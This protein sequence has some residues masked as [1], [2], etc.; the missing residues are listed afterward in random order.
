MIAA[1]YEIVID[2]SRFDSFLD[3][4]GEHVQASIEARTS[5]ETEGPL[6]HLETAQDVTRPGRDMELQA[7]F[8]RAHQILEQMG[9]R[10]A[11]PSL[12][13]QISGAR[14]PLLA[15]GETGAVLARSPACEG[16]LGGLDCAQ[17][18]KAELTAQSG[19]LLDDLLL[20]ARDHGPD[21]AASVVLTTGRTPRHLIARLVDT[22]GRDRAVMIEPLEF[23]WS[24]AAAEMLVVSFGLS[25]AE[26]DL[27]RHLMA[28]RSLRA[29]AQETGKSEHTIRNQAKSVLSKTGAPGQAELIRLVAYLIKDHDHRSTAQTPG[30]LQMSRFQ[31]R[32]GSRVQLYHLGTTAGRTPGRDLIFLHGMLDGVGA[33]N[34]HARALTKRGYRVLAPLRPGFGKSDPVVRP[35]T[36][37]E[38]VAAQIEDLILSY[39]LHR[40]V[41]VGH[42]S[43]GI[44]AHVLAHRLRRKIAGAI[45]VSSGAPIKRMA[46]I[47]SMTGRVRVMAYTARFTPALLPAVLRAGIAI[48][49]SDD[50]DAFMDA[51]FPKGRADRDAIDRLGLAPLIQAGYR[52]SVAQ[53]AVGFA[54]DAHWAI[55]DWEPLLH[56]PAAPVIYLHGAQDPV[57]RAE[58]IRRFTENR[59]GVSAQIFDDCGQLLLYEHPERVFR[60]IDSLGGDVT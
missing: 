39:D 36:M 4:W 7:H 46:D 34:R 50:I 33:L 17:A 57:N 29:I 12:W 59:P 37:V 44:F 14:T 43:G 49:D 6:F 41:L 20:R 48:I 22:P 13:D 2:P 11:V 19:P 54:S 55:R 35:E 24:A 47:S 28:G 25:P 38:V 23:Q 5:T 15:L 52:M 16:W 32:D 30:A 1:I 8:T 60:A 40:P 45:A 10:V 51:Q 9:R 18:L 3:H 27:V 53:G 56:G 21:S 31:A 42:L 26:V 58:R